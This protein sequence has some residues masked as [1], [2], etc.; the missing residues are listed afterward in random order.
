MSHGHILRPIERV[1]LHRAAL[2]RLTQGQRVLLVKR[3]LGPGIGPTRVAMVLVGQDGAL[4]HRR[5]DRAGLDAAARVMA[6][7]RTYYE[8]ATGTFCCTD[9]GGSSPPAR[10]RA[11]R[12]GADRRQHRVI[13]ACAGKGKAGAV[14]N[15]N[16]TGHP[17]LRGEGLT[18]LTRP[19]ALTGSSPPARGRASLAHPSG[20]TRRVIPA[21]AGKGKFRPKRSARQSGHPRLRGEGSSIRSS[22]AWL[23]GSSP[24]A[25]GRGAGAGGAGRHGRVIPACAGKG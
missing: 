3:I 23:T 13:P 8:E 10:G 12:E 16:V 6:A 17:R 19:F 15:V 7:G 11:G 25:R 22:C 4:F 5:L 2:E 24:P 14:A 18:A 21:C 20:S 9:G 1:Q